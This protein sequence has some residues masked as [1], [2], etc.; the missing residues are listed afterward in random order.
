M[1]RTKQ[2]IAGSMASLLVAQLFL[3]V[4]VDASGYKT[5]TQTFGLSSSRNQTQTMTIPD[6]T[7]VKSVT[8]DDGSVSYAVNGERITFTL[9]GSGADESTYDSRKY[10]K[11]A[12]TSRTSSSSSSLG[13][14]VSYSSGSYSGTLYASGS[15]SSYTTTGGYWRDTG[16]YRDVYETRTRRVQESYQSWEV[17][18][19]SNGISSHGPPCQYSSNAQ[20]G[21]KTRT[22]WVDEDYEVKVGTEWVDTGEEWVT[23]YSTRYRR[24]YSGTIYNGGYNYRYQY[25][26]TVT[27]QDDNTAPSLSTIQPSTTAWTNSDV[28]L[29]VTASDSQSGMKRIKLPNGSWVNGSSASYRAPTN[30][31][32]TF[33]AEDNAGNTASK[34]LTVSNI[35]K[36]S[37]SLSLG[38]STTAWTNQ[39]VT[40]T[41]QASDGASGIKRIQKPNGAWVSTSSTSYVVNSNGTYTFK[42]EDVAGNVTTKHMTVSNIDKEKPHAPS[43]AHYSQWQN[44]ASTQVSVSHGSDKG[45]GVAYS[46]YRLEGATTKGWTRYG[47]AFSLTNEGVTTIVARTTDNLGHVSDTRVAHVRL[48]RTKP[49]NTG[50]TI[51]L[52]D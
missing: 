42:T 48:D 47:S 6:L 24:N 32:Y 23:T 12:S 4:T 35:D 50:I 34:S 49:T 15:A 3:P 19:C 8:V 20:Y 28:T 33:V 31:T 38:T 51:H 5:K 43:I 1:L 27:Y 45:S 7:E 17:V 25:K 40:L 16:Y 52:K 22:R 14:S 37:P 41:A 9:S 30:G 2:I 21:W 44:N 18:W 36:T 10:S 39:A 26:V 46:E 29:S 11:S 13:S